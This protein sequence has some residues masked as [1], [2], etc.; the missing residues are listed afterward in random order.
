MKIFMEVGAGAKGAQSG[1]TGIAAG[2][3]RAR[4]CAEGA[5]A[6]KSGAGA[7]TVEKEA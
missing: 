7:G 1:T 3:R 5:A 2:V 4:G 6:W